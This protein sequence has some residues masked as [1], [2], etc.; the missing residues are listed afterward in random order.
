L[1]AGTE[2]VI[3]RRAGRKSETQI[4]SPTP[5]AGE[6]GAR[7]LSRRLQRAL[8][9]RNA[10]SLP[11]YDVAAGTAL[12]NDGHG[13]SLWDWFMLPDGR[14]ALVTL[15]VTPTGFP[16]AHSLAVGRAFLRE[17]SGDGADVGSL[18]RRVNSALSRTSVPGI[19]S[20]ADCALLALGAGEASWLG[21]GAVHGGVLRRDGTMEEFPS[22]G[23]PL[24][25]LDGFRYGPFGVS[26]R[27]GDV[28]VAL[29]HGA[30]GLFKGAADVVAELH[31][32]PAGEVV[33]RLQ[34]ALQ[35]A[36][37][38]QASGE[39]SVLFVRKS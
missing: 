13:R 20:P 2:V 31:G 33:S 18:L 25:L 7:D 38:G 23:P 21:A 19:G 16:A 6:A 17:L 28:V 37:G 24:G 39:H 32:K 22:G 14:A 12:A 5:H 11:G 15:N 3:L 26:L 9:P 1:A 27:A 10:P 34:A 29:S 4:L 30:R 35:K 8:L 36:S